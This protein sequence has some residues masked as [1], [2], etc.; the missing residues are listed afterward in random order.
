[1][2]FFFHFQSSYSYFL[3][4][5]AF[6]GNRQII[7][8]K[9]WRVWK[10]SDFYFSRFCLIE[11]YF[12]FHKISLNLKLFSAT[13]VEEISKPFILFFFVEISL[14][15]LF[16]RKSFHVDFFS[17]AKYF[18]PLWWKKCIE[19]LKKVIAE[20]CK[21][22]KTNCFFHK[23]SCYC[24][25]NK[26]LVLRCC[27]CRVCE[28]TILDISIAWRHDIFERHLLLSFAIT[29]IERIARLIDAKYLFEWFSLFL[30]STQ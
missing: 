23:A 10:K 22:H 1:M 14:I 17:L 2:F 3:F 9:T 6:F 21:S 16:G 11:K 26:T 27:L 13:A 12:F 29:A 30:K 15:I 4:H 19:S 20:P 8:I 25:I 28:R 24:V 5:S 18:H 7:K